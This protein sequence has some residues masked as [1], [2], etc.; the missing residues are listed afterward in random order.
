MDFLKNTLNQY[1]ANKDVIEQKNMEDILLKAIPHVK[2]D[3][4]PENMNNDW[5][6][7]FFTKCRLIS[8][9][10]MQIIW[11]RVLAGEAN[12]PGT[13]L[14][15][16]I[17]FL[18]SLGNYEVEL[19]TNLYKFVWELDS[20]YWIFIYDYNNGIYNK[21]GI[22]Y[23]SLNYLN[24]IGVINLISCGS[25]EY[26]NLPKRITVHYFGKSTQLEFQ[27][28]ADNTLKG[29]QV[30]LTKIGKELVSI[31]NS[32]LPDQEF[33][34]YVCNIWEKYGLIKLKRG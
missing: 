19:L 3:A 9:S 21:H 14:K 13:Y 2:D 30:V 6:V 24:D 20:K 16:T 1:T 18:S 17:N 23:N 25:L 34:G 15:R 8:D 7:N 32:S 28:E 4:K 33:H 27:K 5:I 11:S 26:R 10:D 22:N 12:N 29:G 31:I